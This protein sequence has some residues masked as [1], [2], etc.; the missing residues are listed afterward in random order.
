MNRPTLPLAMAALALLTAL[1]PPTAAQPASPKAA[2][3]PPAARPQG[4]DEKKPQKAANPSP[5]KSESEA[6]P[7]TE[8]VKKQVADG[9]AAEAVKQ[10]ARL[11]S[12]RGKAAEAYDKYELLTLKADAHLRLRA[13]AAAAAAFRQ[14]GE[15]TEAPE[16]K[17]HCRV[18]EELIRRS[19]GLAYVP[20]RP[21]KNAARPEPIDLVDPES[22]GRALGQLFKDEM[23][24]LM[25]HVEAAKANKS[26]TGVGPIIKAM[27]SLREAEY[28]E[29]AV[30]GSADQLRAMV[31]DLR[32][33]GKDVL[34]KAVDRAGK[35][36]DRIATLAN[37]TVPE[38]Q[39]IPSSRGGYRAR[40]IRVP[41]GIQEEDVPVLKKI[42]DGCDEIV[43]Q[44]GA[45][46]EASGGGAEFED[47]IDAAEDLRVHVQ[48][49]LRVHGTEYTKRQGERRRGD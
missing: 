3:D 49:M 47:V 9:N 34:Q 48:R 6:L 39:V 11:L 27:A 18:M 43:A 2:G 40:T 26:G 32:N 33:A 28:L 5:A 1:G 36:A 44:A 30:N 19:K 23:S 25:P 22:R 42:A 13:G 15:A 4:K 37:E 16:K 12:L 38:R 10:I 46:S 21:D 35:Q 45:L 17:A 14:A 24:E 31:E 20:R 8:E 29:L 41:R 7:T